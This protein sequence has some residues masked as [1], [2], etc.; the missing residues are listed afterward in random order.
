MK[1]PFLKIIFLSSIWCLMLFNGCKEKEVRPQVCLKVLETLNIAA[2]TYDTT[3][4]SLQDTVRKKASC[5]IYTVALQNFIKVSYANGCITASD[6]IN[7]K[8]MLVNVTC[9]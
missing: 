7:Y 8:R 1:F 4:K 3:S 6:T 9:K 5:V 2:K